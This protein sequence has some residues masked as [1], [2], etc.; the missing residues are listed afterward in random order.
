MLLVAMPFV[1]SS[2]LVPSSKARSPVRSVLAPFVANAEIVSLAALALKGPGRTW[3]P[4]RC[5]VGGMPR[6]VKH[7]AST[8]QVSNMFHVPHKPE[9]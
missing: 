3:V 9:V 6:K 2:V 5:G 8:E 7:R 4:G 1:P